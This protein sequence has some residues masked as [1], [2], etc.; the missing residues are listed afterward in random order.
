MFTIFL[1]GKKAERRGCLRLLLFL[2]GMHF[3]V[4]LK[5]GLRHKAVTNKSHFLNVPR[6][7]HEKEDILGRVKT[8]VQN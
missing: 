2:C 4:G 3:A 7:N 8:G 6:R 5:G 1:G